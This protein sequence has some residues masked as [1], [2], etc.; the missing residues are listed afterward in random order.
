[1][2]RQYKVVVLGTQSSGKTS[3]LKQMVGQ[4]FQD[5]E[6]STD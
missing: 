1:M 4:N 5:K 3:I 6:K 2:E